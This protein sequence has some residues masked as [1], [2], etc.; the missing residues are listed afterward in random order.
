MFGITGRLTQLTLLPVVEHREIEEGSWEKD[1]L[2][3]AQEKATG[4]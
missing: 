4:K 1:S 3:D 2:D